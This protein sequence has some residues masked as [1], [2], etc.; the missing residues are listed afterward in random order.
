[1]SVVKMKKGSDEE[2]QMIIRPEAVG[3]NVTA[4]DWPL[5]L[6]NWDKRK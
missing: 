5:L 6:K 3:S 1:M 2:Q 4:A